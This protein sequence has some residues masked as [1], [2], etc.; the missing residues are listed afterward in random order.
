RRR[1]ERIREACERRQRPPLPKLH[2]PNGRQQN[3]AQGHQ[4]E[5][6]SAEQGGCFPGFSKDWYQSTAQA[7]A[8]EMAFYLVE[9]R[10]TNRG[11][12]E[13]YPEGMVAPMRQEL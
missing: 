13:M 8:R 3:S 6:W 7:R 10:Q 1:P 12:K 5:K 4:R 9:L 2:V 11:G